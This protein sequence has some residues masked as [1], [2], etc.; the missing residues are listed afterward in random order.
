MAFEKILDAPEPATRRNQRW[1]FKFDSIP[2][3]YGYFWDQSP[4]N[5]DGQTTT[6]E[7]LRIMTGGESATR[8]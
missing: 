5:H 3:D 4:T 8:N 1:P 6:A 7:L 2:C